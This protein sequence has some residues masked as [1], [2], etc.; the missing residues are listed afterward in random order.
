MIVPIFLDLTDSENLSLAIIY[1]YFGLV[2]VVV[3][4]C[5]QWN[6]MSSMP[7]TC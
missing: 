2:F 4:E 1:Y 5:L 7:C 3:L 6:R